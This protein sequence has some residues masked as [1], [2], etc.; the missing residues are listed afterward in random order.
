MGPKNAMKRRMKRMSQAEGRCS[1]SSSTSS[2]GMVISL[3]S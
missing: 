1:S 2:V 3:A